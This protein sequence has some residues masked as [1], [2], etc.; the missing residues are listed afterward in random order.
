MQHLLAFWPVYAPAAFCTGVGL[1]M[2]RLDEFRKAR[3]LF[4]IAAVLVGV[5]GLAW[6]FTTPAPFL[7]RALNGFVSAALVFVVFPRTVEWLNRRE[8]R[9]KQS[10]G[11]SSA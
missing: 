4:W 1:A 10:S 7:L 5:I 8:A 2:I 6:Q 11:S 9:A 3:V